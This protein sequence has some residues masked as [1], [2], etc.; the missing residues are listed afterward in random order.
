M[1]EA[2]GTTLLFIIADL[3]DDLRRGLH[4]VIGEALHHVRSSPWVGNLSDAGFLLKR[5]RLGQSNRFVAWM[6][7]SAFNRPKPVGPKARWN[8]LPQM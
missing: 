3:V 1:T 8:V 5:R 4:H 7:V 2:N 6:S